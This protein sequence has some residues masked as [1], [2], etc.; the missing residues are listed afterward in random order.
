MFADPPDEHG[1]L[2][3]NVP[4]RICVSGSKH[5]ETAALASRGDEQESRFHL[6]DRLPRLAS[7]EMLSDTPGQALESGRDRGQMLGVVATQA[8]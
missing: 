2:I 4:G 3:G 8:R 6:H 1:H 5:G 7:A